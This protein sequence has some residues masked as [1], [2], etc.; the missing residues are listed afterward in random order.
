[1]L[2]NPT[3][4]E[5]IMP[6][7]TT[8]LPVD[9][10][11][12]H[13]AG[14]FEHWRQTRTHPSERIPQHLWDQAAAL[15]QVV[16]YSRVAQHIRVSPSDLKKHIAAQVA[17]STASCLATPP[18]VEVPPAPAC[19]PAPPTL[20]IELAHPDGARLRLRCPASTVPVAAVV[21]AFLEGA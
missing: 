21:R 8:S 3:T 11:L 19:C 18:F 5:A 6:K 14:Q 12:D 17:A 15:A 4:W 9:H 7:T 20:E 1:M 10:H 16:P 2:R 13:L